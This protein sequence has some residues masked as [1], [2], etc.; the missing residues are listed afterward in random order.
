MDNEGL[1]IPMVCPGY[2]HMDSAA[3]A[4]IAKLEEELGVILL[5]HEKVAPVATLSDDDL[6]VIKDLEK[7][8]GLRLVAYA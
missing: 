5:A 2:A 6:S 3:V 8:M 4:K 7:K 1:V